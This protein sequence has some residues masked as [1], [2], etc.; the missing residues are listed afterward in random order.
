M[1]NIEFINGEIEFLINGEIEFSNKVFTTLQSAKNF[2]HKIMNE[3]S[4]WGVVK[5]GKTLGDEKQE[6]FLCR[7]EQ[8][9][10]VEEMTRLDWLNTFI[11]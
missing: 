11:D 2:A 8:G 9:N 6:I 4:E 3:T 7:W 10:P 5:V 1:F